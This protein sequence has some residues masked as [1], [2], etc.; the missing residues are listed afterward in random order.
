MNLKNEI[1]KALLRGKTDSNQW[2]WD[3]FW[4]EG[5]LDTPPSIFL[6]TVIF[7][8]IQK[9]QAVEYHK[10]LLPIA[11]RLFKVLKLDEIHISET[12]QNRTFISEFEEPQNHYHGLLVSAEYCA[13]LSNTLI[14]VYKK[15]G[16]IYSLEIVDDKFYL[17]H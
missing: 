8:R 3:W 10:W 13:E 2:F 12:K 6:V 14:E 1:T 4:N 9:E 17:I 15:V 11:F 5:F 16:S 7:E